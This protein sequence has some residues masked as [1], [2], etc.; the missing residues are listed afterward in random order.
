[1]RLKL[2]GSA[3]AVV[4][5][6]A[7]V[8]PAAAQM[9]RGLELGMDAAFFHY[10]YSYGDGTGASSRN[11]LTIPVSQVRIAFPTS[12]PYE[13]ETAANLG[14]SSVDGRSQTTV[15]ADLAVLIELSHDPKAS[16]WFLRPALGIDH[17]SSS[18]SGTTST[19]DR[20]RITAGIGDRMPL[21]DRI[22]ARYE[23]RY[24]Y[25]PKYGNTT[26]NAIGLLAGISV[27]TR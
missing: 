12:G 3:V 7:A 22:S 24:S 6:A 2:A 14:Y 9:N 23:L 11:V 8:A 27:F 25:S 21:T 20:Y 10:S 15:S 5:L 26:A 16:Q 1:M 18:S 19:S 17:F 13:I 4:L